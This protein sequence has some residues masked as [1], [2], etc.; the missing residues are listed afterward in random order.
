M[1]SICI[2]EDEHTAGLLPLAFLRPVYDLRCGMSTLREKV[3][4]RLPKAA[5]SLHCRPYLAPVLQERHPLVLVNA[6]R[7]DRCIFVNGRLIADAKLWKSLKTKEDLV[8][9]SNG[10]VVGA[11]VSGTRLERIK[12]HLQ[13]PLS[14][15][16]FDGIPSREIDANLLR[17]P[18]ELVHR[19]GEELTNDVVDLIQGL[20]RRKTRGTVMRGVHLVNER[21][22][23][24]GG[25]TVVK[26]GVVLDATD[27]PIVIG[28]D[29][30]IFPN[31]T[32]I[33]PAYVGDGSWI[34]VG[35]EIYGGTTIGP[36]CKVGGE[37]EASVIHGYSNK[38]HAG[39]LGHSYLGS[40]VNIGAG[41][42]VSDLKNNYGSVVVQMG[43]KKIDTGLQFVGLTMGDH[44][45]TAIGTVFNTG[46]VVGVST[47]VVWRGFPP[48]SIPSFSWGGDEQ[49]WSSYEIERAVSV[50]RRVM[51]RRNVDLTRAEETL[52]RTVFEMTRG[53]RENQGISD[54]GSSDG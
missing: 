12:D 34:K 29:V 26:P 7:A 8:L 43:E 33:G 53:D 49:R 37:V 2:F 11:R 28:R 5:V 3:L 14:L 36:M 38:Q 23:V 54:E 25:G 39:F 4:R 19:N 10:H 52:L 40:W 6:I 51:S 50:A 32:I 30:R 41:T 1:N 16:T 22:V 9:T 27:G 47:N 31:A 46:T 21:E 44:S 20:R 48:K 13:G 45:K 15:Q 18:W 42:N 17:Y 24:V 35:A